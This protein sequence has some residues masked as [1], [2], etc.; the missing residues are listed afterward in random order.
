M[1]Q[2]RRRNTRHGGGG[3]HRPFPVEAVEADIVRLGEGGDGIAETRRGRLYIPLTVPGD[4][5][6]A[7]PLRPRS[8]G[9]AA[10]LLEVLAAGPGRAQPPCPHFGIC[11][12]CALQHL[13]DDAYAAWKTARLTTALARVGLGDCLI[14]PLVRTPPGSR[15]RATFAA[16]RPTAGAAVR[17]GFLVRAAH[18]VVD[19]AVCRVLDPAITAL[20]VPLRRLLAEMLPAGSRASVSVTLLDGELDVLLHGWAPQSAAEQ[21]RLG[22]FAEEADLARLSWQAAA[23]APVEPLAV[24]RPARAIFGGVPVAVPP[25]GFL[26]ASAAGEAALLAA[27]RAGIGAA[28][29]VCDLFCGSGTFALPLALAGARVH[30]VDGDADALAAL[31]AAGRS[32]PAVAPRLSCERRDLLARPLAAAELARFAA[33]VLDPPRAGARA[34]AAAPGSAV[35]TV[36]YVSC[37]P[38]SFARDARLLADGGYRLEKVTPVD[39]FLWSPHVELAAVFRTPTRAE[40]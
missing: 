7:V 20:L 39:Q 19:L 25:A 21:E 34:Q 4:R 11:G 30:G 8:K 3:P 28:T 13:A 40:K 26:Q 37:N 15:R 29:E 27:V 12:G 10:Q 35:P 5:V 31:A 36:V 16:E 32:V 38:A 14:T 2:E 9:F 17:L 24:R 6:R 18:Q 1:R 33:V 23:G 22:R